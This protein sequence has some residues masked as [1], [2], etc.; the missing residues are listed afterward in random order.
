VKDKTGA[1]QMSVPGDWQ[2]SQNLPNY[3][4]AADHSDA[5]V[6]AQAG[7]TG[8]PMSET[9]Q[10]TVGVDKMIENSAHRVFWAAKPAS[11]SQGMPAVIGY[12][13][14][15]PGKDGTCTAQITIRQGGSE[16]I[17]RKIAATVM[18]AK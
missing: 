4:S 12:H 3:A 1:C 9:V 17:V 14:T 7:K 10:K 2:I 5:M 16:D 6:L 11:V 13:V 15:V 8:L 18:V